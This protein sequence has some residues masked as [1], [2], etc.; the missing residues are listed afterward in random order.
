[1]EPATAIKPIE[2]YKEAWTLIRD[3]YW[4][5][6]LVVFVGML[7]ANVVPVI[8]FGPMMCGI[9]YVLI[10]KIDGHP[11]V[12][13]ELFE[14]IKVLLPAFI[15]GLLFAVPTFILIGV[16][17]APLIAIMI[18]GGRMSTDEL[19]MYLGGSL[20]IELIIAV[21]M[22]CLHTLLMFAFPLII[23]RKV[24]VMQAVKMSAST[25]WQNLGGITGL[26]AVGFVVALA[27]MMLLCV[28]IYLVLP[29]ILMATAVTYRRLFPAN[30]MPR[31]NYYQGI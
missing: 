5:V 12:F 28:G 4:M 16:I 20:M 13:E 14:G 27:G 7:V 11:L 2:I 25:V 10:R 1:M 8:V 22:V 29:V 30:E 21:A 23:D 24:S 19:M 3:D 31:P 18:A 17:Y 15:V 26:Y 6:L 9:F